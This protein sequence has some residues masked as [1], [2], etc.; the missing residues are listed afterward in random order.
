MGADA[1]G[2]AGGAGAPLGTTGA[3]AT[4]VRGPPPAG[5]ETAAQPAGHPPAAVGGLDAHDLHND[6]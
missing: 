6:R 3:A 5:R 1:A 4:A 2:G